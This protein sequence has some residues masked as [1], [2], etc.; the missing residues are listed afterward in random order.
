MRSTLFDYQLDIDKI[1]QEPADPR[2]SA[3]LMLV[4]RKTGGI[5]DR[6]VSDLTEILSTNNV[7]VFN[8]T[9]V[10]PVRLLGTKSTGGK[11]EL[12]LVKQLG[13]DT[14]EAIS[15]PGLRVGQRIEVE[16]LRAEVI[17]KKEETVILKFSDRGEFLRERI[18][19]FG[20]TPIPPYIHSQKTERELRRVYQTVYAKKEGSVAAPT[21]GLHFS[22][23]LLAAL[24][25]KG[26]QTE[27]LTL[28]VGLGTFRGVKTER[29][30]DHEMQAEWFS[31][32]EGTAAR[33]NQAKRESKKIIAVG[34]TTTRVLESCVVE[35][36]SLSPRDAETNIFIYP[37]YK[38]RFV[39]HLLTNFHLPKSTLLML[40]SAF[41]SAP[42][43]K[44][45]F[46]SFKSS[47]MGEAYRQAIEN[48]YRFFSFG[49]AMLIV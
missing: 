45:K 32:D 3:K 36:D 9:K 29:V 27:F 46:T 8:Q 44:D 38:F 17:E 5:T 7:L 4:D 13:S 16:A 1:A 15:K 10:I 42:N 24:Q 18:F 30:E 25:K 40:A 2:D 6:R 39:D 11:V 34:T 14:W 26:V 35:D 12:L 33:L 22:R 48:G 47:L 23:D 37:P 43:T 49:D 41:V 31:L 21:A 20:K 19:E 28:H